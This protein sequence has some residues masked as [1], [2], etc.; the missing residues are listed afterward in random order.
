MN[1]S[2]TSKSCPTFQR[3]GVLANPTVCRPRPR[4]CGAKLRKI[5]EESDCFDGV[6][7]KFKVPTG[8]AN[9]NPTTSAGEPS[10]PRQGRIDD[11]RRL[12]KLMNEKK[13]SR[14]EK[15]EIFISMTA[16]GYC[17]ETFISTLPNNIFHVRT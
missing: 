7:N 14:H 3:K 8:E 10:R 9:D 13:K 17:L 11:W 16:E 5:K 12:N 1:V 15:R 4:Y 2:E 6:S